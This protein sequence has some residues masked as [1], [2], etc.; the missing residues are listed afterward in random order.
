[1]LRQMAGFN[2][3][4][5]SITGGSAALS[6]LS[7]TAVSSLTT[8]IASGGTSLAALTAT[9]VITPNATIGIAGTGAAD[10]ANAGRIGEFLTATVAA[11]ASIT[12]TTTVTAN[13]ASIN[14]TAG[15]WDVTGIVDFSLAGATVT[16]MRCGPSVATATLPTQPG[17]GGLGTDAL[18]IFPANFVTITDTIVVESATVRVSVGSTTPLF[19][20][21]Q[22]TFSLGSVATFGT[23]RARR[24]R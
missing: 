7:V 24:M 11:A 22:A 1:M 18:V 20:T 16:D 2:A 4:N 5:V 15:D 6:S 14:V 10:N 17:G 21:A 12:M 8:L 19:L 9:G 3:A 23:I 13:I